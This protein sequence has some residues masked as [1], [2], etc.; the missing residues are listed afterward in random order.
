MLLVILWNISKNNNNFKLNKTEN[1]KF[2]LYIVKY[3][4]VT[5]FIYIIY[6]YYIFLCTYKN[7]SKATDTNIIL[8]FSINCN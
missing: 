1:I 4:I 5:I 8:T 7:V 2:I 3:I 6:V